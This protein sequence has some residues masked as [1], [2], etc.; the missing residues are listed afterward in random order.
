MKKQ[1]SPLNDILLIFLSLV[2]FNCQFD[3]HAD[4]YTTTTPTS[5]DLVGTY[6]LEAYHLP[7]NIQIKHSDVKLQL[8]AG[9]KFIATNIPPLSIYGADK[10]FFSTLVSGQGNWTMG[11]LGTLDPGNHTLWGVILTDSANRFHSPIIRGDNAPY[12]LSFTLGD[13]D[14]GEAVLLQKQTEK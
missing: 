8:F 3:P 2:L 9:G 11:S 10:N 1:F 6:I 12:G 4:Q 13:P 14:Q 7:K 5:K